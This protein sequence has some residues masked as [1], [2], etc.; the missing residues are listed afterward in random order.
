MVDKTKTA[1]KVASPAAGI[2]LT[3]TE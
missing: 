3:L 2:G 1:I